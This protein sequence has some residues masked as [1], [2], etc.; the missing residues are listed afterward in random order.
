MAIEGLGEFHRALE[1]MVAA[2]D[3]AAREV[4]TKGGHIVERNAKAAAN[5]RPGPQVITGSHRRSF[6]VAHIRRVTMGEWES[7][8]GPTMIYSR[9]LELGFDGVD[10]LGRL[11]SQPPYPSLQPGLEASRTE[12]SELQRLAFGRA[13]RGAA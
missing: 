6:Q 11:Y 12:L 9:R 3:V 1:R 2:A 10:S 4:V 7:E 8:T 13:L 5:G